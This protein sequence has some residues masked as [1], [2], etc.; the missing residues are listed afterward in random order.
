MT[1][2]GVEWG[3]GGGE[4]KVVRVVLD[5]VQV[6]ERVRGMRDVEI[7]ELLEAME[8]DIFTVIRCQ[9]PQCKEN[10]GVQPVSTTGVVD[11]TKS[12]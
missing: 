4:G 6:G 7:R 3:V 8:R 5:Y 1:D 9:D 11:A 2:W 10:H 12:E